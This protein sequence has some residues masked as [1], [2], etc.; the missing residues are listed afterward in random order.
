M[1]EGGGI[2]LLDYITVVFTDLFNYSYR[3]GNPARG[4]AV[5]LATCPIFEPP[6]FPR[7]PFSSHDRSLKR[8]T[9]HNTFTLPTLSLD[10]RM[11]VRDRVDQ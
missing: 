9:A 3:F 11:G 7:P 2:L 8:L 6:S 5:Q 1:G 4:Q 10:S